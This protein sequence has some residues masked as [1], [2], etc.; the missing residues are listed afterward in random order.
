MNNT[1]QDCQRLAAVIVA[2]TAAA[3]PHCEDARCDSAPPVPSYAQQ[4]KDTL[5]AQISEAPALFNA[6]A[7]FQPQYANLNLQNIGTLLNGTSNAW[8]QASTPGM[9]SLYQNQ[10]APATAQAQADASKTQAQGMVDNLRTLGPGF[11]QAISSASPQ[12]A[13]L[14]ATL[15]NQ[16]NAGLSAGTQLTADQQRQLNNQVNAAQSA[17]GQ[18]YG[19]AAAYGSVMANSTAGQNMLTQRQ[20]F[21][22][23]VIGMNN[24]FYTDPLLSIIGAP[25]TSTS[26]A[27]NILGQ[28][29]QLLP[30]SQFNPQAGESVYNSQ[31]QTASAN[32][33]SSNAFMGSMIGS[34]LS[35]LGSLGSANSQNKSSSSSSSAGGIGSILGLGASLLSFL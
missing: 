6:N 9:L 29:S 33:G 21:A 24:Q 30:G 27:G 19:P 20:N 32:A 2:A 23:N 16:A 34:G 35:A 26:A 7:L 15:N 1:I 18:A 17:R 25:A 10:I 5:N 22:S 8:G 3:W 13:Q 4:T 12:T 14:L 11:N 31:A 28:S